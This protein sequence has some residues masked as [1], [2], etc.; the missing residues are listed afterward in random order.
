VHVPDE[1][2]ESDRTVVRYRHRLGTDLTR[3]KARIKSLLHKSGMAIPENF[4][5][6]NWTLA[7][8]RWLKA[9]E[10]PHVSANLALAR[11]IG[12]V[13]YFRAQ[14]LELSGELRD[15]IRGDRYRQ[16]AVLLMTAPGIGALTALTMLTEIGDI[17]RFGTFYR[18]NSFIGLCPTEFS[19]GES[20][21]MGP[22]TPR[23][24]SRLRS[25]LIE[26][27][28]SAV[29]LD[30]AMLLAYNEYKKRMTGKRAIIRIARKMLSRVYY[31][32]QKQQSYEKGIVK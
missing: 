2:L 14:I 8:M 12:Q 18:F 10:F 31:M 22:L 15:M 3:A 30:P 27:A 16:G 32:L 23:K 13:E 4:Q 9:V 21:R 5:K 20:E 25:L 29:R 7:F 26:T 6:S 1:E 11:M 24:H 19:S 28:W 17:G